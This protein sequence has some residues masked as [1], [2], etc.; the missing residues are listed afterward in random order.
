M[1]NHLKDQIC[2]VLTVGWPLFSDFIVKG[3][4][5]TFVIVQEYKADFSLFCVTA[6]VTLILS[7]MLPPQSKN[8]YFA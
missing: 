8:V 2:P 6:F 3:W 4:N 1:E 5:Q 7:F